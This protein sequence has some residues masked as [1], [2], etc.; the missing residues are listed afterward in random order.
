VES[1]LIMCISLCLEC[2][3][4]ID[5]VQLEDAGCIECTTCKSRLAMD[6]EALT[7]VDDM[8]DCEYLGG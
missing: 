5:Q 3:V 1:D 2:G 4:P 6:S 7:F 8:P